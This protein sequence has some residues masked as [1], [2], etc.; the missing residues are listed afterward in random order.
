MFAEDL[1]VFLA[2]FGLDCLADG[3]TFRG[4][5]DEA[6]RLVQMQRISV[7][8]DEYELTYLTGAVKLR[9][10]QLVTVGGRNF[11]VRELPQQIDDGA[12]SRATISPP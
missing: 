12:F 6:D 7:S 1:E 2:D 11:V 8:A 4:L 5:L 9:R 3:V 10:E